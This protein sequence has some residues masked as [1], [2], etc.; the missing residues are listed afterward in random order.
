MEAPPSRSRLHCY[1]VLLCCMRQN[2]LFLV[3]QV[4]ALVLL[5]IIP[6]P[7]PTVFKISCPRESAAIVRKVVLK[8]RKGRE[9]SSRM[10]IN[11]RRF[12]A[13]M[14]TSARSISRFPSPRMSVSPATRHVRTAAS[15]QKTAQ[16]FLMDLWL[17]REIIFRGKVP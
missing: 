17:L 10:L 13:E 4:L 15:G 12:V 1:A 2:K 3:C 9:F 11:R 5:T 8:V 16:A 14:D 6:W 7:G